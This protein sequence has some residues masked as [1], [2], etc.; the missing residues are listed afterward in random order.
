MRTAVKIL[1]II[2]I[3]LGSL[4]ILGAITEIDSDSGWAFIG[5]AFMLGYGITTLAYLG[6]EKK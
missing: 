5:G 6:K 3:V 4:A 2:A 1:S